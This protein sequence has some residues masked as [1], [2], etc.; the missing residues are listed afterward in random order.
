MRLHRIAEAIVADIALE[1]VMPR[2]FLLD[3]R[4][5]P[6]AWPASGDNELP[7]GLVPLLDMYFAQE[8][9]RRKRFSEVVEIDR[10]KMTV[11]IMPY[12]ARKVRLFALL[13]ERFALR[14]RESGTPKLSSV[15]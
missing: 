2:V 5:R 4:G 9:A 3:E 10:V 12:T 1:R 8:P 11:R 7:S 14:S 13:L 6:V 15:P